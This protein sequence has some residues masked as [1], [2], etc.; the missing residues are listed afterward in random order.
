VI[1]YGE[2]LVIWAQCIAPD[3]MAQQGSDRGG[4]SADDT[5]GLEYH[6]DPD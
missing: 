5:Y 3:R 4:Q 2:L 1:T 6:D